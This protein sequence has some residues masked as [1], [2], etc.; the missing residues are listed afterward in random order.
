M[1]IMRKKT[2]VGEVAQ[3]LFLINLFIAERWNSR[4]KIM[5]FYS[6]LTMS[7]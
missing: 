1:S 2:V 5:P 7:Y 3:N 6:L 4:Y